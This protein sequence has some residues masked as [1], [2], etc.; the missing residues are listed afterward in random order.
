MVRTQCSSHCHRGPISRGD[1]ST[2][3][4]AC[5]PN[6]RPERDDNWE[7]YGTYVHPQIPADVVEIA[8]TGPQR[9][10]GNRPG[11]PVGAHHAAIGLGA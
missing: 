5:R 2:Q 8:T 11:R 3:D 1:R 10:Q 9:Q 6:F 4:L 7:D